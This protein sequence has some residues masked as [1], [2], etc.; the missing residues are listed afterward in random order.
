MRT[1]ALSGLAVLLQATGQAV[2]A[3][4]ATT[5]GAWLTMRRTAEYEKKRRMVEEEE[6]GTLQPA[7]VQQLPLASPQVRAQ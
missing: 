1:F 6:E 7:A 5:C 3:A 4:P 2:L